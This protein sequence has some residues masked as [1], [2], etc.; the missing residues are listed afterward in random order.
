MWS[1]ICPVQSVQSVLKGRSHQGSS[2]QPNHPRHGDGPSQRRSRPI[3]HG[4]WM[5]A[6]ALV[7]LIWFSFNV[8]LVVIRW[9]H[10]DRLDD[11]P[12]FAPTS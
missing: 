12:K 11:V 10:L 7:L 4:V 5:A 3:W 9:L 2:P 6:I 1:T 8:A